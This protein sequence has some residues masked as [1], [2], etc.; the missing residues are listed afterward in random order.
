MLPKL[1]V[2]SREPYRL[3]R[4]EQTALEETVNIKNVL[5]ELKEDAVI[6]TRTAWK[7]V[8]LYRAVACEECQDGYDG[9]VPLQE[10]ILNTMTLKETLRTGASMDEDGLLFAEDALYKAVQGL[11]SAEHVLEVAAS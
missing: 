5:A 1:C 8:P 9:L 11:V 4:P 3:S 6:E 2:Q 10:I 7:D